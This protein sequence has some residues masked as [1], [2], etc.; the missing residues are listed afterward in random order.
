MEEHAMLK[1][2]GIIV[3]IFT[4]SGCAYLQNQD[5]EHSAIC[6]QLKNR[7][8]MNGATGNKRTAQME[9]SELMGLSRTYHNENCE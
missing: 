6:K 1:N 5:N 2:L 9:K 4:V 7:I 3:L 8:I